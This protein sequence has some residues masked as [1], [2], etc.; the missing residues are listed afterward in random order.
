ME[1]VKNGAS[2]RIERDS[3]GGEKIQQMA[4]ADAAKVHIKAIDN[5]IKRMWQYQRT[6]TA[7]KNWTD[8]C[9]VQINNHSC[10]QTNNYCSVPAT[11]LLFRPAKKL[12]IQKL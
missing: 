6:F 8:H 11:T 3:R 4:S 10:V 12:V 1:R 2:V 9:S 7:E 5:G